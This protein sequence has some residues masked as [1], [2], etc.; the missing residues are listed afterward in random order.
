MRIHKSLVVFTVAG[1]LTACAN[2]ISWVETFISDKVVQ[3]FEEKGY[4]MSDDMTCQMTPKGNA[5]YKTY[6]NCHGHTQDRRSA[7][8]YGG[9]LLTS[10]PKGYDS[11]YVGKIDGKK[12]LVDYGEGDKFKRVG[13]Q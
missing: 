6:I 4:P 9:K 13:N 7:L 10:D 3:L 11:Y 2:P 5:N 1:A 8:F 12:V